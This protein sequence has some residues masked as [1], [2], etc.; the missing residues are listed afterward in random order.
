MGVVF[1]ENDPSLG[2][3]FCASLAPAGA[4]Q[5]DGTVAV[6]DQ[7]VAVNG[8]VNAAQGRPPTRRGRGGVCVLL[9]F[10]C[11][12]GI[13]PWSVGCAVWLPPLDWQAV[14]FFSHHFFAGR[15]SVLGLSF[16][17]ALGKIV[18]AA[19]PE[20]ELLVF[21]GGA[22]NLYGNL[23]PADEWLSEKLAKQ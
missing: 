20:V 1:E 8:Q 14:T 17:D 16:D 3:V 4:A 15:Q 12:R 23:G 11:G 13:C 19:A 6:G 10:V 9:V 7:L 5:V 21:R 2:G 22:S 18:D